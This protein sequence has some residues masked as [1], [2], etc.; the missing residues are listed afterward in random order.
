M[1]STL[2]AYRSEPQLGLALHA[3]ARRE[4]A[5]ALGELLGRCLARLFTIARKEKVPA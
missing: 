1:K 2:D 3:A 4:R 5:Q